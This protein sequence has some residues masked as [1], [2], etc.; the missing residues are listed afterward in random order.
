[1]RA[2]YRELTHDVT[3][4]A[5]SERHRDPSRS[6][7]RVR[8]Q[9]GRAG[10]RERTRPWGDQN[11]P[12]AATSPA[13]PALSPTAHTNDIEAGLATAGP[14]DDQAWV[15]PADILAK[16]LVPLPPPVAE[17][18]FG[19]ARKSCRTPRR[20]QP[21]LEA[22]YQSQTGD[23]TEPVLACPEALLRGATT[24]TPDCG[25]RS[26]LLTLVLQ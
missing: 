26:R 14:D 4:Q 5:S 24:C 15:S 17:G 12:S 6:R 22:E 23:F 8:R 20:H 21:P 1:M 9:P 3:T 16:R 18:L 2:A 11:K 10:G 7:A 25:P 19:S 13:Q